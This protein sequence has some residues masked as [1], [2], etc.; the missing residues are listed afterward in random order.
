MINRNDIEIFILAGG[1]STRMGQD[2]GLMQLSGKPMIGYAIEA[3]AK[4]DCPINILA[5][6]PAYA[7]FGFPVF[8]DL[9]PDKGPMG[10]LYTAL[11]ITKKPFVFLTSCDVPYITKEVIEKLFSETENQ[12]AT[13]TSVSGKL[14]PT[15]SVYKSSLKNKVESFIHGSRLRM[16]DLLSAI[17]TKKINMDVEVEKNPYLFANI[18]SPQD[19]NLISDEWIREQV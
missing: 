9:I 13:V 19:I 16:N 15:T 11:S 1:K 2:K 4:L 6:D 18:N 12:D 14:F 7:K 17:E 8:A 3:T 5:N 10:G